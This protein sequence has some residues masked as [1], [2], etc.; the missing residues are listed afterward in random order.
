MSQAYP[1][2]HCSK[3]TPIVLQMFV[4]LSSVLMNENVAEV[5]ASRIML[6]LLLLLETVSASALSRCSSWLTMRF[7]TH[8]YL[9]HCLLGEMIL[10]A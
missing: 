8:Y 10:L 2:F 4:L 7:V 3:L 1:S 9:S 5:Y 6:L